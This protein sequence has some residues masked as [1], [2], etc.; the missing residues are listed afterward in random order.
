MPGAHQRLL[1]VIAVVPLVLAGCA[2]DVSASRRGADGVLRGELVVQAAASLTDAFAV[3]EQ[4]F[5]QAHPRLDVVLNLAGSQTLAAQITQGAPADVFA[6]ADASYIDVVV[7]AGLA[8]GEPQVFAVNRLAIAVPAGN[9]AGIDSLADLARDDLVTV[10]ADPAVP[11]GRLAAEALRRAG[12]DLRPASLAHDVRAVLSRVRLG[13]ADAG[14]VYVTD[15][16]GQGTDAVPIA[17]AHNVSTDYPI[18]A[19]S[20]APNPAAAEAFVAYVLSPAG[21]KVLAGFGF[22]LP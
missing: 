13:E 15:L 21:R 2:T 7:A 4:R 22:G 18:V 8:A 1:S 9:P 11:A 5:E 3:I 16:A 6:S 14:I 12:V 20:Q 19:L 10:V 17:P